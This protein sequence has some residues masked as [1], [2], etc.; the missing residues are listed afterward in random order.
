M[1]VTLDLHTDFPGGPEGV[2]REDAERGRA[3]DENVIEAAGL[4]PLDLLPEECV[5]PVSVLQEPRP[6]RPGAPLLHRH[7]CRE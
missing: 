7:D 1:N 3:V 6:G 2:D 5:P 4:D